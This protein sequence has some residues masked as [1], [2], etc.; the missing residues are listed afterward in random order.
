MTEPKDVLMTAAG[1]KVHL[2]PVSR[3][4][5]YEV[6]A[7][8]Q[9]AAEARGDPMEPPTY[10]AQTLGGGEETHPHDAKSIEDAST[11]EEERAA[12]QKYQAA[13]RRLLAEIDEMT[14]RV[15][16]LEGLDVQQVPEAWQARMRKY[17]VALPDNPDELKLLYFS[18]ELLRVPA[19]MKE[20]MIKLTLLSMAGE[21]EDRI[22][23]AE[24]AFRGALRQQEVRGLADRERQMDGESEAGRDAGGEGVGEGT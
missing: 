9:R 17:G 6:V 7:S 18:T 1:A 24:A 5:L 21:P 11:S 10:T 3:R 4:L 23:A 22:R 16:L 20:A 19:D 8:C 2:L 14:T 15:M 12:W 13:Q